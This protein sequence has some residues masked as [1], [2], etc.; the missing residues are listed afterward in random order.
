MWKQRSERL[1]YAQRSRNLLHALS[2][3]VRWSA[4]DRLYLPSGFGKLTGIN[5]PGVRGFATYLGAHGVPGP[6]IAWSGV[7]AVVEFFAS[8]AIVL[9]LKTRYAAALL[10]LVT[11]GAALIGHPIGRF[12]TR[13][14]KRSRRSISLR[15]SPLS[16]AC[17]L[18]LSAAQGRSASTS[19]SGVILRS[20]AVPGLEARC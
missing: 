3:L 2:F 4:L 8:L 11:I 19:K 13:H 7:A 9:G 14:R 15:T 10:I 12:P 5:G 18:S 16:A 17:Y 6:A 20:F 1:D